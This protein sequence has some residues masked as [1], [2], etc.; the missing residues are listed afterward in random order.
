MNK[1]LTATHIERGA[2]VYV[3]MSTMAQV[4][5]HT[6]GRRRQYELVERARDLGFA[7]VD[8]IDEDL[9]RSGSGLQARP[10]FQKLVAAICSSAVGAVFCL[11]ASRLARNGRDWHHLLDLCA[12]VGVV[13]VDPEGAYDPRVMNDRLL[14]GLKGTMSEYEL[15]LLRQRSLEARDSKAKRGELRFG[16]PPGLVW[17]PNGKIEKDPDVRI[18]RAI[19][20]VFRKFFEL[21]T[22]RQT[23]LWLRQQD[24]SLPVLRPSANG[25]RVEWKAPAYHNLLTILRNPMYAGA[26]AFGRTGQR[27]CVVDGR[28]RRSNGHRKPIEQWSVLIRDHHPGYI[29][30]D[31]FTRNQSVIADNAHMKKRMS[32]KAGRGGRAL[33]AGMLRCGRCGYMMRVFYGS[34]SSTAYRY[35]CRSQDL[36]EPDGRCIGIGGVRVDR[37]V[38]SQLLEALRPKAIEAAAQA[39]LRSARRSQDARSAVEHELEEARYEAR[40][41]AR[42]Y[43]AVDPDKRMVACELEARW[44][45][46]LQRVRDLERRLDEIVSRD[47][48]AP[49]ADVNQLRAMAQSLPTIWNATSCDQKL[50]Q[51]ITQILI[52]EVIANVDEERSESVIV[53]H[54]TGGRHTELRVHRNRGAVQAVHRPDAVDVVRKMAGRYSDLEIASTLNRARRGDSAKAA[55]W[56]E[57]RV[58]QLRERLSLPAF[59]SS[60][61]RQETLTR[62]QTAVRLGICVGSVNL[63]IKRGI[64]PAEQVVPFAPWQIP[65][66]ALRDRRVQQ[67]VREIVGRRPM[68]LRQYR[69]NK[70]LTLPGLDLGDA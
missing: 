5:E 43:E 55:A 12:L 4:I 6:E 16:L 2:I 26:Y 35:I 31:E 54:W 21:G 59:D 10:G 22:T 34:H 57:L 17:A 70:T 42:R 41:A 27:T 67:G 45:T 13:L 36:S 60:R 14:L 39:A 53:I 62:D 37:A 29:T 32:R 3:R 46:A 61:P 38:A 63:L 8:V 24:L 69:E 19:E 25:T 11:E 30:W 47:E 68:N 44:E 50:K 64:L 28:A 18:A 23:W 1:K 52:K 9:G 58:R 66:A 48:R 65:E 49:S 56:S 33:L 40:L 7:S 20:L 51:R 15:G